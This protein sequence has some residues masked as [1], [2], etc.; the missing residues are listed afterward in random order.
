M[1]GGDVAREA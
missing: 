1:G